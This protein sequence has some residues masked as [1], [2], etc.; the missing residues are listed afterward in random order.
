M[1]RLERHNVHKS[2]RGYTVN[3]REEPLDTETASLKISND[4]LRYQDIKQST[5]LTLPNLSAV[6]TL[7]SNP[8]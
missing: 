1:V 6:L 3:I 8:L 2:T 4:I 5:I 7:S